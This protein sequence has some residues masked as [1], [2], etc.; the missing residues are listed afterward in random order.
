MLKKEIIP[1][2]KTESNTGDSLTD[3]ERQTEIDGDRER[4][5]ETEPRTFRTGCLY[6]PTR[7]K[8]HLKRNSKTV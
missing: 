6:K 5:T 2:R 7:Q 3:R 8:L 4:K 1:Q